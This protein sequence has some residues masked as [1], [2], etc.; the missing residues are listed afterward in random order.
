[1]EGDRERWNE[2]W[3]G[4]RGDRLGE[5][6]EL[7]VRALVELDEV[8]AGRALDLACGAGRHALMLAAAGW[9][10]TGW[11]VSPVGLE[12]LREHASERGLAVATRVVD[13]MPFEPPGLGEPLDLVLI[14]DYLDRQLLG[15]LHRLVSPGGHAIVKGYTRSWPGPRPP[16]R[17]RLEP[18]ELSRGL[19]GFETLFSDEGG[20]ETVLLGKR[21]APQPVKY[22]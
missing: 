13:L 3:S 11:D 15:G 17:Y 8:S 16:L 6:S 18:G 5:P 7:V 2:Q 19:P 22:R 20:G 14:A 9:E 12:L 1:M 10:C 4:P 21:S